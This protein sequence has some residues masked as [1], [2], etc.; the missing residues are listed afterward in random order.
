MIYI[1]I[2]NLFN[3]NND[4]LS[5]QLLYIGSVVNP[6]LVLLAGLLP[7]KLIESKFLII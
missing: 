3:F 4:I 6:G 7:I 2:N 1:E 5:Y